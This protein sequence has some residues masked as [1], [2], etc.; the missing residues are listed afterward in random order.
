MVFL[1]LLCSFVPW[2]VSAGHSGHILGMRRVVQS[3][4]KGGRGWRRC[5]SSCW[6]KWSVVV[7]DQPH[8]VDDFPVVFRF[9]ARICH[10][11]L[12]EQ[13]RAVVHKH[14]G[15]AK[16]VRAERTPLGLGPREG[17]VTFSVAS[18]P[19]DD[20]YTRTRVLHNLSSACDV[21][22]VGHGV[23]PFVVVFVRVDE[24]IHA[25]FQ[26][27]RLQVLPHGLGSPVA[28]CVA[29]AVDGPMREHDNP[30]RD[31]AVPLGCCEVLV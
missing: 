5:C 17:L 15:V 11:L 26:Q 31:L 8:P 9:L 14:P 1:A 6:L 19:R 27:Q 3:G 24:Q 30:R 21:R 20:H 2:P 7:L 28:V 12:P 29:T 25:V 18:V 23:Q 4:R 22:G 10:Y 16:R 13:V